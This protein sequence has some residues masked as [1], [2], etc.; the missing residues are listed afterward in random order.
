M[1]HHVVP[2]ASIGREQLTLKRA[3]RYV[4]SEFLSKPENFSEFEN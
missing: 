4:V 1:I 3:S 2:K